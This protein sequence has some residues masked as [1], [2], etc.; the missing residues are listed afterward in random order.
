MKIAQVISRHRRDVVSYA[1]SFGSI[2][3]TLSKQEKKEMDKQKAIQLGFNNYL[4]TPWNSPMKCLN[5][6][7]VIVI[8]AKNEWKI[9]LSLPF[10]LRWYNEKPGTCR[11]A[12]TQPRWHLVF[13]IQP[14]K[15]QPAATEDT[16]EER[17]VFRADPQKDAVRCQVS[18]ELRIKASSRGHS[19]RGH[20]SSPKRPMTRSKGPGMEAS[21]QQPARNRGLLPAA[22]WANHLKTDC[23]GSVKPSDGSSLSWLRDCSITRDLP[24]WVTQLNNISIP[25]PKTCEIML[26][27]LKKKKKNSVNPRLWVE[28]GIWNSAQSVFLKYKPRHRY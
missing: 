17:A 19:L 14:L 15:L 1:K 10:S 12:L 2:T 7:T 26:V 13:D 4:L 27:V 9:Q 23:P 28:T 5:I 22:T 11:R 18:E 20:W 8:M 24:S 21:C 16:K 25:D 6:F 3:F